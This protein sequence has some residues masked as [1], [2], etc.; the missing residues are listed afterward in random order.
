VWPEINEMAPCLRRQPPPNLD[1]PART[2]FL[3]AP[4]TSTL[5]DVLFVLCFMRLFKLEG[6]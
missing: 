6:D 3:Y 5:S 4:P 1:M 2:A